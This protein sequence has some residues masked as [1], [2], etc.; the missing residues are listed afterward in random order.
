MSLVIRLIAL[1]LGAFAGTVWAGSLGFDIR[2]VQSDFAPNEPIRVVVSVRS[3]YV[4]PSALQVRDTPAARIVRLDIDD[5]CVPTTSPSFMPEREYALP[6]LSPGPHV[7]QLEVCELLPLPL[8]DVC[9]IEG[10][11]TFTVSGGVSATPV[12]ATTPHGAAI[13]ISLLAI[14]SAIAIRARSGVRIRQ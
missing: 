7:V 13:L 3:C 8:E 14:A 4:L 10:T 12:P 9:R 1:A 5:T 11:A 2:T 6:S